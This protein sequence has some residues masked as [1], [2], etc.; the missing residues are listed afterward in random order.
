MAA[1]LVLALGLVACQPQSQVVEVT[2]IVTET[3]TEE[4][5]EV[6]VTSVVTE[7]QEV[8]VTATPEPVEVVGMNAPDPTTLVEMT[9]GDIDTLDPALAYDTASADPLIHIYETLI[10]YD[11]R[12][13]TSYVPALATEVP[14]IE[15]GG[16]SADG[17]TYTFNIREGVTFHEGQTLEPSDVAYSF[18]RGLLPVSYTH[19]TLPTNREV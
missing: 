1:L 8:V 17:K 11:F 10:W 5:Q 15:N 6:V 4:G 12:D 16:I 7:V 18:Q 19:L 2:R 9:F 3:I 14:S 13:G